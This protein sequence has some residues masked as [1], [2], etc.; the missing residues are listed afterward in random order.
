LAVFGEVVVRDGELDLVLLLFEI[1]HDAR[2]LLGPAE[3]FVHRV[4][5][6]DSRRGGSYSSTLPCTISLPSRRNSTGAP[7]FQSEVTALPNQNFAV[8]SVSVSA[9][10]TFSG[11]DAM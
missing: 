8:T 3:R 5:R 7:A 2:G 11:V 6:E 4:K 10:K 9:L 1:D